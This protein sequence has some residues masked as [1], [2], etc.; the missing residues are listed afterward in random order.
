MS[1]NSAINKRIGDTP[2]HI[3]NGWDPSVPFS[4]IVGIPCVEQDL[5]NTEEKLDYPNTNSFPI[6]EHKGDNKIN[7]ASDN[8]DEKEDGDE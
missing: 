1:L 6:I 7:Y 5:E 3:L 2:H 4:D 8:S